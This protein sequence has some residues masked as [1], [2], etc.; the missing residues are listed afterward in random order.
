[1]FGFIFW[2]N[3]Q[4]WKEKAAQIL[5]DA[6]AFL[7]SVGCSEDSDAKST[8]SIVRKAAIPGLPL[9]LCFSRNNQNAVPGPSMLWR[10]MGPF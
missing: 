9:R 2:L 7:L 5:L 3:V 8:L 1:L 4:N 6:L 10:Q